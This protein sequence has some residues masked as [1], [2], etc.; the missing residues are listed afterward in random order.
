MGVGTAGFSYAYQKSLGY[1]QITAGSL[2]SA[3]GFA[4]VPASAS[5]ALIYVEAG[6]IRWRDDGTAPTATVGMPVSAGQAF[7]YS[8]PLSA[9]QFIEQAGQSPIINVTFVA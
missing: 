3:V 9:I 6:N 5:A 2:G 4:S 1:Q 8:G 7:V